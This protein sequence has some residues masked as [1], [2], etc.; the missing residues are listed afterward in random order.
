VLH[1]GVDDLIDGKIARID[2]NRIIGGAQ[3]IVGTV[4]IEGIAPSKIGRNGLV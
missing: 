2:D 1:N 4:L 3:W